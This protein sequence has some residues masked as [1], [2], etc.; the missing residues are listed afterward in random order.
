MTNVGDTANGN[1][2]IAT[3][4]KVMHG[5]EDVTANYTITPVAGKLT[6]LPKAVTITANSDEFVYTGLTQ[7]NAGYDVAGLVGSDTITAVVEGSITFPRESPVTN[8]LKSYAFTSGMWF[9]YRVTKVNGALT[10]TNANEAITITAAS[11]SWTYDGTAH[12]NPAV[13]VTSGALL[14]GDELVA[15]ATGSVTNV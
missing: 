10:M 7:S 9:N 12:T 3:G 1:N 13:S 11:D 6:I 8:V 14:T 2:P 4:Y 5:T 15:T